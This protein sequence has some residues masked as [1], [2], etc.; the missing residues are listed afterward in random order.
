MSKIKIQK[1]QFNL[2]FTVQAFVL[3]PENLK[4]KK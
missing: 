4:T 2:N 3:E 1:I